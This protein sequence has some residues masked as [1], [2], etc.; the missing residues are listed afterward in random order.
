MT[1]SESEATI[2]QKA[3]D[4]DKLT[5]IMKK[6]LQNTS[7]KKKNSNINNSCFSYVDKKENE[8]NIQ[9]I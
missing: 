9:C 2:Q 7:T 8:R 5:E 1:K 4:M 6:Q 3:A